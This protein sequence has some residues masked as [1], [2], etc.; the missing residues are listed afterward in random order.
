MQI[1][2][3]EDENLKNS[4]PNLTCINKPVL[5][6]RITYDGLDLADACANSKDQLATGKRI[7]AV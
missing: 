3:G 2:E 1:N 5:F 7:V 4:V 6:R